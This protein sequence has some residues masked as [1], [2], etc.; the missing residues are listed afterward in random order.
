MNPKN[1]KF[2]KEIESVISEHPEVTEVKVMSVPNK[3][4][5]Q[6]IKAIIS[7]KGF[8][9]FKEITDLCYERLGSYKVPKIIEFKLRPMTPYEILLDLQDIKKEGGYVCMAMPYRKDIT[10]NL[11]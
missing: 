9:T 6:V 11:D 4:G 2:Y 7:L 8:V 3:S 10:Y 1:R 5:E